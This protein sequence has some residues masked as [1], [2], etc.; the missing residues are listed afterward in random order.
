[1]QKTITLLIALL[2]NKARNAVE[3]E[4]IH[5]S[6]TGHRARPSMGRIS[7]LRSVLNNHE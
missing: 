2:L 4:T 3:L 5:P 7:L 6:G 1:M